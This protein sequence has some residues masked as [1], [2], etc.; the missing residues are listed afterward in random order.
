MGRLTNLNHMEGFVVDHGDSSNNVDDMCDLEDLQSLSKLRFLSTDSWK[1]QQWPDPRLSRT[2]HCS[3][4]CLCYGRIESRKM[5]AKKKRMRRPVA[6]CFLRR[7]W[8]NFVSTTSRAGDF[9]TG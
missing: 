6:D 9:P 5:T 3:G 4:I 7:A 8:R 2:N 1:G